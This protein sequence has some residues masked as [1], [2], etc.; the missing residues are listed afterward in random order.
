[1]RALG[2]RARLGAALLVVLLVVFLGL[3]EAADRADLG[4]DGALVPLLL[5]GF[6]GA[7]ARCLLWRKRE[8][9]APVVRAHVGS[10]AVLGRR[11]VRLPENAQELAVAH[12]LRIELDENGLGVARRVGRNGLV[13]REIGVS[14][15]VTHGGCRHA[16][17]VA[18]RVLRAPETAFGERCELVTRSGRERRSGSNA[19]RIRADAGS[20]ADRG[21]RGRSGRTGGR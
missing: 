14:A 11:I 21:G 6:R 5:L 12:D 16:A 15:G 17:Q 8:D 10:L 18:E 4:R 13:R 20:L 7:G 1:V 2:E 3:V 9:G 19:T